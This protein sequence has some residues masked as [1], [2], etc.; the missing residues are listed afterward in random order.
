MVPIKRGLLDFHDENVARIVNEN[1]N[2]NESLKPCLL[3]MQ[4]KPPSQESFGR[5]CHAIFKEFFREPVHS[6]VKLGDADV[7]FRAGWVS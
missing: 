7:M 1:Q 3:R 5:F 2:G 4:L 6:S